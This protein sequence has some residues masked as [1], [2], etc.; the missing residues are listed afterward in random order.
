MLRSHETPDAPAPAKLSIDSE[1]AV[2]PT[3][4]A[5]P[6]RVISAHL[7]VSPAFVFP[8]TFLWQE[9]RGGVQREGRRR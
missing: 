4:L 6:L 1:P 2:K 8:K 3:I 5:S 7:F 9:G